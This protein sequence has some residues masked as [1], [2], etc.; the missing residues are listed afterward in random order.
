M[1]TTL[2]RAVL[3]LA[4]AVQL[5]GCEDQSGI[6]EISTGTLDISGAFVF[7]KTAP[8]TRR[9]RTV[10]ITNVGT[11]PVTLIEF[12]KHADAA[13]SGAWSVVGQD[14]KVIDGS[15]E[16]M[17]TTVHIE[18]AESLRLSLTFGPT[19]ARTA[20]GSVR[21]R[22][23]SGVEAQRRISLPISGMKAVGEL[24]AGVRQVVFGRVPVGES[25]KKTVVLTNLGTD[26]IRLEELL[27]NGAQDFSV[28][29][30]NQDPRQNEAV[31]KDPDG[32]RQIGIAP[33]GQVEVT[34][35]FR[36]TADRPAEGEL[37]VISDAH[38][39][40]L[41]IGLVG[42]A[43]APCV[44]VRPSQVAFAPTAVGARRMIAV[45]IES[46]GAQPVTVEA[47]TLSADAATF[48][49]GPQ[50]A[51]PLQLPGTT[52]FD[53][54]P[55]GIDTFV[56]FE[57]TAVD[58]YEARL[59]VKS[60]SPD[61]PELVIPVTGRGVH[62]DCPTPRVS[63]DVVQV[64]PLDVI[65]LDGSAST[66]PDGPGGRPVEYEWV[67]VARPGGSTS[68]PVESLY[69]RFAPAEGGPP[70]RPS[71]PQARFFV[72]LAGEYVVELRVV[73]HYGAAAPSALCPAPSALV[74]IKAVPEEKLHIQLTWDTPADQ[75]QT[76]DLG[77][78]V[79]LHLRHPDSGR[80]FAENGSD[81]F[82]Q[83]PRPDWGRQ[84][85]P[86]DDPSLDID[87]VNGAGPENINI[88]RPESTQLSTRGYQVGVHYFAA[89]G[90]TIGDDYR[91]LE[92]TA[93]VRIFVDGRMAYE[94]SKLLRNTDDFWT[95]AEVK[96]TGAGGRVAEVDT[97]TRVNP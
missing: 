92:S 85:D 18:P 44:R 32:D 14:G 16:V 57:P 12:T 61:P 34:V 80:W 97:L 66:D 7:P 51:L 29:I 96:F 4:F 37:Q 86:L 71:T 68:Q 31:L 46:C 26:A 30:R 6:R 8:G 35:V 23:N 9:T 50:P 84:G 95:V 76:D 56:T 52:E 83:N 88:A 40:K 45:R 21:L 78:D 67:V 82:Y 64:R 65:T 53:P 70:D 58:T 33:G 2:M 69:D 75:D 22:T 49:L 28:L 47:V 93:T 43:A 27:M 59:T 90:P 94:A 89:E 77:T 19:V 5:F 24:H 73:D 91:A 48:G 11:E 62:N 10:S 13:F 54:V 39:G 25:L 55:P 74:H 63:G 20:S 3:A 41:V 36:P 72:D 42:N 81:C 79:D 87:D 17:P 60:T 15:G 1:K 38:N